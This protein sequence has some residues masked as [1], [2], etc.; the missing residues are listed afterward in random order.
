MTPENEDK[1]LDRCAQV[2]KTRNALIKEIDAATNPICN[3]ETALRALDLLV[4]QLGQWQ[5][6]HRQLESLA[7]K[8]HRLNA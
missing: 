4:E 1:F 8:H 7:N 3:D 2:L 5:R 6:A